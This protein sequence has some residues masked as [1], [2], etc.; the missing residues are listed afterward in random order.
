MTHC[1]ERIGEAYFR[2]PRSTVTAFVNLLSVL[3]QNPG[4][5][6]HDLIQRIEV[7]PDTGDDISDLDEAT[8]A[9]AIGDRLHP[10]AQM[11]R[12]LNRFWRG[13]I[14]AP[15][16]NVQDRIRTTQPRLQSLCAGRLDHIKAVFMRGEED[17]DHLPVP[18]RHVREVCPEL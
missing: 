14:G 2:T 15:R 17:I 10:Q 9:R 18:I 11:R 8:G 4:I 3:E 7:A 6:W 1:S 5:E 12:G 13:W 16:D